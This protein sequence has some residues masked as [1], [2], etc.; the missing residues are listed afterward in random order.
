[1]IAFPYLYFWSL[2]VFSWIPTNGPFWA[3]ISNCVFFIVPVSVVT[4][5]WLFG[6]GFQFWVVG[7]E[8]NL[9]ICTCV[10]LGLCLK[11][12]CEHLCHLCNRM[13]NMN[14][15]WSSE[16]KVGP[17]ATNVYACICITHIP[18]VMWE[19][20][21][22][23]GSPLLLIFN[24]HFVIPYVGF[25]WLWYIDSTLYQQYIF[26]LFTFIYWKHFYCKL[27]SSYLIA[28]TPLCSQGPTI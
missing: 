26:R 21:L 12:E 2:R 25:H 11:K 20:I 5:L 16:S 18:S 1:M 6:C 13:A 23:G 27:R 9:I 10:F 19:I 7:C 3:H 14:V 24:S 17:A 4:R 8:H 28:V 15:A 22:F